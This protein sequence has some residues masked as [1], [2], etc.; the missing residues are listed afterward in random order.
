[1]HGAFKVG[2]L[3]GGGRAGWVDVS[4]AV[5]LG[6]LHA[7]YFVVL[8]YIVSALMFLFSKLIIINIVLLL[9]S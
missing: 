9:C 1:M 7:L 6:R 8:A 2:I 5:E 3:W 4:R